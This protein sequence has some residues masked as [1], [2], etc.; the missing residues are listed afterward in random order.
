MTQQLHFWVYTQKKWKQYLEHL[1][2][3][4]YSSTI[5]NNQKVETAQMSINKQMG[6]QNM[7]CTYSEYYL[8]SRER[9]FGIY[10]NM[11]VPWG[12]S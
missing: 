10:Y 3:Y 2:T 12:L 5:H 6:K 4:V 9:E 7:I 8:D 1:Y 11:D